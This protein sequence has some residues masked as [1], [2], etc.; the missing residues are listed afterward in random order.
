MVKTQFEKMDRM[1]RYQRYFYDLTR[2]FYLL[3]RDK[4]LKKIAA[5]DGENVLEIGCGTARNLIVLAHKFPGANFFGLDASAEMLKTARAKIESK[6][7]ENITVKTALAEEF[8]F[9]KTFDLRDKFDAIFFSYA[10]SIIPPWRESLDNALENLKPGGVLYIVDFYD[11]KELPRWFRK[12]LKNWLELFH[13][14]YPKELIPYLESLEER[15]A[16]ELKVESIAKNYA[17][18]AEFRKIS[19]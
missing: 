15:G 9:D 5:A 6:R 2:K 1:Y 12:L 7:L 19:Q 4:L 10:L 11:G 14:A 17:F 13:V 8:S 3:G 16:G 18:I